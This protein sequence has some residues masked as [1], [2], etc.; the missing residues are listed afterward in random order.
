[1]SAVKRQRHTLFLIVALALLLIVAVAPPLIQINRFRHRITNTIGA[2]IGRPVNA[3]SVQFQL[4]PR[5]AIVLS[6]FVVAEE[7][8]FGIEP[9]LQAPT[10]TAQIRLRS[11]WRGH[12]RVGRISLDDPSLNLTRSADG[13][14]SLQ[15]LLTTAAQATTKAENNQ[16]VN[17]F[18]YIEAT[19][20]RVN[21][22]LG[23]EKTPFS[24]EDV[25]LAWS[26]ESPRRWR[27]R[28]KGR[29]VRT[30]IELGDSGTLRI[31]GTVTGA[32][33]LDDIQIDL[34]ANWD[35]LQ[36]GEL[37]QLIRRTDAGWRGDIALDANVRGALRELNITT[38]ARIFGL[39][40]TEF[41]PATTF[42]PVMNCTAQFA[43]STAKFHDAVCTLPV[44]ENAAR[45][46]ARGTVSLAAPFS[47]SDATID[48][49]A[50]P[51]AF[52]FDAVRHARQNLAQN[53]RA[54]GEVNGRFRWD[55]AAWH[56]SATLPLLTL[57]VSDNT[58]PIIINAVR[59]GVGD[60]PA[61]ASA[62]PHKRRA[63][64]KAARS[65]FAANTW[66][67]DPVQID[68]GASKPLTIDA[69][70]S[71]SGYTVRWS[72]AA[73]WSR[74]M[75]MT[76]LSQG[77]RGALRLH[78]FA[79]PKAGV[80][81]ADTEADADM[82]LT[83]R[84]PWVDAARTFQVLGALKARNLRVISPL[85]P[86]P[87][88]IPNASVQFTAGQ[89][90]WSGVARYAGTRVEGE[91]RLPQHCA[92]DS[93]CIGHFAARAQKLDLAEAIAAGQPQSSQPIVSFL[94]RLRPS[95][96]GASWPN[97]SGSIRVGTFTAG[98]LVIHDADAMVQIAGR[99]ATITA[100][101][102]RALGGG[103]TLEGLVNAKDQ[104]PNYVLHFKL[105]HI[106]TSLAGT[107]FHANW[108]LGTGDIEAHLSASANRPESVAA[109]ASGD[110]QF[111]LQ[112]GAIKSETTSLPFEDWSATGSIVDRKLTLT[113]STMTR[114]AATLQVSG[115]LGFDRGLQ[116]H[117]GDGSDETLVTGTIETPVIHKP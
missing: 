54:E 64:T 75:D 76:E 21:L 112:R 78:A 20:A 10:V 47:G 110:F 63:Q 83:L 17:D 109:S 9:M 61:L 25:D 102:G 28:L 77:L 44:G 100:M 85:L 57:S 65:S 24:L 4:L 95:S 46:E 71:A 40:R 62:R 96:T 55:G 86:Q 26:S 50:I 43:H 99:T 29:P 32:Q 56:G 74:L 2:A 27:V 104:T 51:A 52:L 42:D 113:R 11:L 80:P 22:K 93:E 18:P 116:L 87:V 59:V 14:W 16:H 15:K 5:P 58:A 69:T 91:V 72:G 34:N 6:N 103:L 8:A 30:D 12:L 115:A 117:I 3:D 45:L 49:D 70:A 105:H 98:S 106:D 84:A 82:D 68:L 101:N 33:T 48:L 38:R 94:E 19:N 1:M 66:H 23:V 37:T 31:E 39:R 97:L 88:E 114:G 107:L 60:A 73:L 7:P 41:V 53:L 13:R 35:R 92:D 89:T 67:L 111:D 90:L 79:P 81:D 36:L 108:N